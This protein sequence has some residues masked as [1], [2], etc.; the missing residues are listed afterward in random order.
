M[1]KTEPAPTPAEMDAAL[2]SSLTSRLEGLAKDFDAA[3]SGDS[4]FQT[5][6]YIIAG[7]DVARM[8]KAMHQQSGNKKPKA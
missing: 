1:A 2:W 4:G 8:L 3:V 6:A 5:R 7:V